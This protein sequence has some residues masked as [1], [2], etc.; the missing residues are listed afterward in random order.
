MPLMSS[1]SDK[2]TTIDILTSD[3]TAVTCFPLDLTSS[4]PP[5]LA[6]AFIS[7]NRVEEFASHFKLKTV[8]ELLPWFPKS[9]ASERADV[10][11]SRLRE[12]EAAPPARVQLQGPRPEA[13]P[14]FPRGAAP[15]APPTNPL[16]IGRRDRD[17][18]PNNPFAPPPLFPG[19]GGDGMFVGPDHPIF[20]AGMRGQ[21]PGRSGPWGG[22]GFLPPLGAP[23][24]A[25]FDPVGPGIGPG[26][27]FPGRRPAPR[28]GGGPFG[29]QE[30]DFDD[31]PPPGSVS[32][33]LLPSQGGNCLT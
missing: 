14:Q 16:E 29:G 1:Q 30:P 6:D 31:F 23:A 22:D 21:S 28:G 8:R 25:R 26:A 4:S 13:P 2:T 15:Y 20:G 11:A 17:P 24:G 9:Y 32:A 18:F 12:T 5:P 7:A 33:C 10:G 3:L 27:P 19:N